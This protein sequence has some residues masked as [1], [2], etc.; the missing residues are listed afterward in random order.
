MTDGME[1]ELLLYDRGRHLRQ[2]VGSPSWEIILDTLKAYKDEAVEGLL[3][4]SPGDPTVP[5]AH[6]AASA[7]VDQFVKFQQDT[8]RA[9]EFAANPPE[10]FTAWLMGV[11]EASDVMKQQ[12]V[13][14]GV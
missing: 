10:E 14:Y 5:T 7:L 4:L 11:A 1:Q 12:G 6:A 9:L 2:V 3:S 13:E 8:N